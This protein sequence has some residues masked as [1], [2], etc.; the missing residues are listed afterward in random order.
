MYV[1]PT[2]G[3][4]VVFKAAR[5]S[6]TLS[7]IVY[8]TPYYIWYAIMATVDSGCPLAITIDVMLCEDVHVMLCE[9]NFSQ[10]NQYTH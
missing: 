3:N 10:W 4:V 7:I 2:Y 9:D 6:C 1:T 5:F 8:Q